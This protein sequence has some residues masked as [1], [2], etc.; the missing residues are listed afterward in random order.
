MAT[1]PEKLAA[2]RRMLFLALEVYGL[3]SEM[4]VL[5]DTDQK[6][7]LPW[8]MEFVEHIAGKALDGIKTAGEGDAEPMAGE[9]KAATD[10]AGR[11]AALSKG[12]KSFTQ[13]LAAAELAKKKA[14]EGKQTAE[15]K[16]AEAGNADK[17]APIL[18]YLAKQLG[19]ADASDLKALQQKL[20]DHFLAAATAPAAK[21]PEE[22]RTAAMQLAKEK[23][24]P[25]QVLAGAEMLDID[26]LEAFVGRVGGMSAKKPPRGQRFGA[27]AHP[28]GPAAGARAAALRGG[29]APDK[30]EDIDVSQLTEMQLHEYS[31]CGITTDKELQQ[32][33]F[34]RLSR[35]VNAT[36][37]DEGEDDDDDTGLTG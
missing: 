2:L 16:L 28:D 32:A 13:L 10:S 5:A 17:G 6:D 19:L 25:P 15:G 21:T 27:T 11:Q 1:D 4:E 36:P 7:K 37:G 12:A 24:I 8:L 31:R 18:G 9:Y 33:E 29:G 30:P 22:R 3:K 34:L 14:E 23:K 35:V 26:E 20:L